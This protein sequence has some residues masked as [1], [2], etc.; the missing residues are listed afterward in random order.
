MKKFKKTIEFLNR[1][2]VIDIWG[3]KME[4][5][6]DKEIEYMDRV[7]TQNPYGFIG[8]ILGGI[9]FT[10]GPQ[11]GFIP[12]ITLIFCIVTLFT[13]DKE[14]EDN[15]WPF[16]LGIVLSLIGLS[17]FISGATHELIF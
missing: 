8:L 15:P 10:F 14:K 17:M 11:Y 9:A 13:F 3:D 2:K 5:I 16:Y 7:P 4:G 1:M 12:V 6:S